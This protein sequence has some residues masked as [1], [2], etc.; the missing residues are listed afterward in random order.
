MHQS[1]TAATE[2]QPFAPVSINTWF[3]DTRTIRISYTNSFLSV[4]KSSWDFAGVNMTLAMIN[5]V[6]N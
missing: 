3:D 5:A 1:S 4:T 2:P 6:M